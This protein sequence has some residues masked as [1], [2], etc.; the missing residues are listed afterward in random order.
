MLESTNTAGSLD[1]IEIGGGNGRLAEDVLV[2]F[3]DP[4]PA[5]TVSH[6]RCL[7]MTTPTCRIIC[8][9]KLLTSTVPCIIHH[10]KSAQN[11]RTCNSKRCQLAESMLHITAS[12]NKMPSDRQLGMASM[13]SL[14]SCQVQLAQFFILQ[15][16][17]DATQSSSTQS[18]DLPFALGCH[19]IITQESTMPTVACS[20]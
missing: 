6:L 14:A 4:S 20:L 10:W 11:W 12:C 19:Q 15:L 5:E 18:C 1:I 17:P 13:K 8:N 2:R 9:I 7:L 3:C 16:P